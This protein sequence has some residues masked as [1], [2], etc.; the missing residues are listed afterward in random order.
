M[1]GNA[2]S[3]IGQPLELEVKM[4]HGAQRHRATVTLL[5]GGE[6]ASVQLAARDKGL[7]P[8]QFAAFYDGDV[9]LG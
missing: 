6:G 8:G 1:A 4:R 5:N 2:P 9:C 3:N 7:A